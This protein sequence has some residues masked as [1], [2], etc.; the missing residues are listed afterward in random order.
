[1]KTESDK[2]AEAIRSRYVRELVGVVLVA[3]LVGWVISRY[4]PAR[5]AAVGDARGAERAKALAEMNAANTDALAHYG[6]LDPVRK[7]VRLPVAEAMKLTV[8][9]WEN[10]VTGRSNLL[11]RVDKASAPLPKID[12]E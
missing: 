12:F 10:P 6:R 11:Q 4:L 8:K 9:E 1:M 5:P 3:V 2:A 7:I